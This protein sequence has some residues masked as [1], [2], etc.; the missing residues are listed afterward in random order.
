[1]SEESTGAGRRRNI[2]FPDELWDGV[3]AAAAQETIEA[4]AQVSASEW[5]REAC[6]ERLVRR[7]AR[8]PDGWRPA[9]GFE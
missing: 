6:R 9:D 1:M 7:S 8:M 2:H 4:G 3:V 5:V